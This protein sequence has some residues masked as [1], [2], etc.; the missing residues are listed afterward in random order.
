MNYYFL[1][2]TGGALDITLN[3]ELYNFVTKDGQ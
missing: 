3:C 1:D 2:E